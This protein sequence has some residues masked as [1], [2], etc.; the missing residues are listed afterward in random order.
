MIQLQDPNAVRL[1]M[2]GMVEGN[3]H[4]Y[5]WSAII[6]G[7]YDAQAMAQCGYPVILKYLNAAPKDQL[8]IAGTKVT[9]LWCDK[10]SDAQKSSP[11]NAYTQHRKTSSRCHRLRRCSDHSNGQARRTFRKSPSFY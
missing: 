1:A 3:G 6:N 7:E 2:V 5:S 8:G 9:H 4:P 10:P 11:S